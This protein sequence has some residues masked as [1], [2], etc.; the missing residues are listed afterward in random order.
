MSIKLLSKLFDFDA[1][2]LEAYKELASDVNKVKDMLRLKEL[3]PAI[4]RA[5]KAAYP[6][7]EGEYTAT[8]FI[9]ELKGELYI[10]AATMNIE[11]VPVRPL[12]QWNLNEKIDQ[13][14]IDALMSRT[15]ELA[16]GQLTWAQIID[17]LKIKPA[18][19]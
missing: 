7:Q 8:M 16:S 3:A 18:Q 11:G 6:L 5:F 10:S 19:S 17:I 14:N 9:Q 13:L 2:Q 12:F 15:D 4:F 1:E